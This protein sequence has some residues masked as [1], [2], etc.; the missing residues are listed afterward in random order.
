[1]QYYLWPE[2]HHSHIVKCPRPLSDAP[3]SLA[4]KLKPRKIQPVYMLKMSAY[5]GWSLLF[6]LFLS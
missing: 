1:M 5:P 4:Q 6:S 3:F 2:D